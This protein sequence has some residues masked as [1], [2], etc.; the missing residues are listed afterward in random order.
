[1]A[2]KNQEQPLRM[3]SLLPQNQ[4]LTLSNTAQDTNQSN[5]LQL[6]Q[7]K[8]VKPVEEKNKTCSK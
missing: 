4:G 3:D 1:M 7:D 5:Q 6:E 8:I 2:F